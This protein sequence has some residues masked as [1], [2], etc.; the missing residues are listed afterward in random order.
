MIRA[1]KIVWER[2]GRDD[3]YRRSPRRVAR[4]AAPR[5]IAELASRTTTDL[6]PSS[7]LRVVDLGIPPPGA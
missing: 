5:I 3:R 4:A 6:A 2:Q 1:A 7:R